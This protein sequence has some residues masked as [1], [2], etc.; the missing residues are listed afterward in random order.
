M[1][2]S[3]MEPSAWVMKAWTM[4]GPSRMLSSTLRPRRMRR[5]APSAR[6]STSDPGGKFRRIGYLLANSVGLTEGF[7]GEALKVAR[8]DAAARARPAAA[9]VEF[10]GAARAPRGQRKEGAKGA[11]DCHYTASSQ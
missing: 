2:R 1:P 4:F 6:G 5:I 8:G 7:L 11:G 3:S 9:L 10:L